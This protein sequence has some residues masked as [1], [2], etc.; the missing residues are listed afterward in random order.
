MIRE[1][2]SN[3]SPSGTNRNIPM[4]VPICAHM[5]SAPARVT[6]EVEAM[7]DVSE[8][9]LCVVVIRHRH[10]YDDRHQPDSGA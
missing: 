10:G 9:R 6:G 4:A 2:R 8:Q 1:R 5:A 7:R 3:L